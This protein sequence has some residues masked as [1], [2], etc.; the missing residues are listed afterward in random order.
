MF[1]FFVVDDDKSN[2][3]VLKTLFEGKGHRVET[4]LSPIQALQTLKTTKEKFD[5]VIIDIMMPEMDGIEFLTEIKAIKHLKSVKSVVLTAKTFEYD[6]ELARKTGVDLYLTKPVVPNVFYDE[7][8]S[9]LSQTFKIKFWGVRGTL[10]VPGQDSVRYGGNTSCVSVEAPGKPIIVFDAG[11]GIK[12]LGQSLLGK[13]NNIKFF[14]SHGHWDHINAFPFFAPLYVAGNKVE[15]FGPRNFNKSVEA[16]ISEQMSQIYFPITVSEFACHIQYRDLQNQSIDI[17]GIEVKSFLL[18]H[19]GKCLGYALHLADKI[20]CYVTDNEIYDKNH[21][22][23]SPEYYENLKNFIRNADVLVID[24]TY[25]DHEYP[26]KINWGH[27][28]ISQV[29]H[30]AHDANV[31]NLYL[32]HHDPSQGDKEIDEKFVEAKELLKALKSETICH[33]PKEGDV[34]IV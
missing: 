14:L 2:L 11:S 9:L 5:C 19:P 31:K 20:F 17:S 13:R 27:S 16:M 1:S 15:V 7:V 22:N 33:C 21:A 8:T 18:S 25:R 28:S 32:F 3:L 4:E 12:N 26:A 24:S 10:P 6:R 23:H 34:V 30:L 29:V